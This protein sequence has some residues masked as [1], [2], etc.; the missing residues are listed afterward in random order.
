MTWATL[1]TAITTALSGYTEYT[2]KCHKVEEFP[3]TANKH[4]TIE[5]YAIDDKSISSNGTVGTLLVRIEI[6]FVHKDWAAYHTDVQSFSD[7][8]DTLH[9]LNEHINWA[10]QPKFIRLNNRP[11]KHKAVYEFYYGIRTN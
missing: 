2:D 3:E 6:L 7:V 9:T 4:Y 11:D 5:A 10:S 1:K 8:A